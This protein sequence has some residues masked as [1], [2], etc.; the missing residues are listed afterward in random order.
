[1][2][3]K[4]RVGRHKQWDDFHRRYDE[5]YVIE[6]KPWFGWSVESRTDDIDEI[7]DMVRNLS[8]FAYVYQH[9]TLLQRDIDK[10][11][12]RENNGKQ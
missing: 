3:S 9:W 11:F 8:R 4:Y 5:Y 10:I 6:K 2:A 1:M 7:I 12:L